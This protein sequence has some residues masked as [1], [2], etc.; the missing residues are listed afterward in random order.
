MSQ[1][2]GRGRT[3]IQTEALSGFYIGIVQKYDNNGVPYAVAGV[4]ATTIVNG[5]PLT[6]TRTDLYSGVDQSPTLPA[7][8][9]RVLRELVALNEGNI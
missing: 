2:C 1:N 5:L 9:K 8:V 7:E 4:G 6:V 3:K